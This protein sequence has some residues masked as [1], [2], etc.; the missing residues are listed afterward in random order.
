MS[1]G[2]AGR[3]APRAAAR[4]WREMQQPRGEG[5][6]AQAQPRRHVEQPVP[7]G[8]RS[9]PRSPPADCRCRRVSHGARVTNTVTDGVVSVSNGIDI[10]IRPQ[11][12]SKVPQVLV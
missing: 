1:G 6:A 7:Q 10:G 12:V 5:G 8:R 4:L 9:P 11:A 3:A 2:S